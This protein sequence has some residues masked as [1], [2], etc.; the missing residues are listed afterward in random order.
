MATAIDQRNLTARTLMNEPVR[1]RQGEDL[2]KV[3]DYMLDL[4]QGCVEYAVL[5]FGGLMGMGDKLFAIPW[6][7]MQLDKENHQWVLDVSKQD[8]E[9]APGFDKDHW[10]NQ[11]DESWRTQI[12]GFWQGRGDMGR[13]RGMGSSGVM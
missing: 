12:N 3:E 1:N 10:P 7:N 5:S 4:E 11:A 8:L 13:T 9:Q 6:Q 2:G